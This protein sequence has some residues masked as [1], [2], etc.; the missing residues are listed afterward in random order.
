M[1][2]FST[3]SQETLKVPRQ[4]STG[5]GLE[6]GLGSD[7]RLSTDGRKHNSAAMFPLT[8]YGVVEERAT[9]TPGAEL[10]QDIITTI[11][12]ASKEKLAGM[13]AAHQRSQS[14]M[15]GQKTTTAAARPEYTQTNAPG[16]TSLAFPHIGLHSLPNMT[17]TGHGD[18]HLETEGTIGVG[19]K[20]PAQTDI[21][22]DTSRAGRSY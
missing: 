22:T 18:A 15:N 13:V 17:H 21:A 14:L 12:G 20:V 1:S 4:K 5:V 19:A 9:G 7:Y 3:S 16:P 6:K 11:A 8:M 10:L 2:S